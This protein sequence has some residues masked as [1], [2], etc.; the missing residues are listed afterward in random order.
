[1]GLLQDASG[2]KRDLTE[3]KA[4]EDQYKI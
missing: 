3:R 1:M 2:S 4:L